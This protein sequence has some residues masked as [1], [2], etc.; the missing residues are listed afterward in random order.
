[1]LERIKILT[2][3]QL[4][5]KTRRHAKKSLRVY[6]D[7]ALKAIFVLILT[8]VIGLLLHVVKNILFIPVNEYFMIFVLLLTQVMSIITA[9][10]GLIVDIYQSKDN[11]IILTLP[12][13]N[14]EIFL[15]KLIVYYIYEFKKNFSFLFPFLVAYGFI[16]KIGFG[17]YASIIPM[18]FILPFISVFFAS[19]I[20][21]IVTIIRNYLNRHTWISFSL[22]IL[23]IIGFFILVFNLVSLI[24][25]NIRIVQL[26]N[27]FIV[28]L[29]KFMQQV[30]SAGSVYTLIGKLMNGTN[31]LI[32]SLIVTIIILVLFAINFLVSRP[33]FFRL[34]SKSNEQARTIKHNPKPVKAKGLFWT[35]LRKEITI[36]K[37]SPNELLDN[38]S[39]LIALPLIIFVLNSIYMNMDRSS[40]GN[41]FILVFNVLITL[42]LITASNTASAAAI[43]TEGYEFVLLKTAP[44]KTK[45][46]AWAK[47]TFN[48]V[49]T[50][51]LLLLSFI[52]FQ[53]ALPVFNRTDIWLL[54][55][56]AF[57]F[58]AS[59][60]LWSFQ[61]D[62]LNPKLSDYAATGSLSNND[63]I[64]KALSNGFA[65]SVVFTMLSILLFVFFKPIAWFVLIAI[66]IV[67]LLFRFWSFRT[68]IDAYFV[69]IEY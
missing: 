26:Y 18:M 6:R 2:K 60:I 25:D 50:S 35:F 62:I 5:N 38:Y 59:Q 53:I 68:C 1:M 20:S 16:T 17:F 63:N 24:P 67:W 56:F 22:I 37:R 55:I 64:A 29:T 28:G 7:F 21:I 47:M 40:L 10:F 36:A 34:T 57:F 30:A 3:L 41:H 33:L 54:F 27:S 43:T 69:D 46:V 44:S 19:I 58:N 61:I 13:K 51:V 11:Q 9:I 8:I 66:A 15:S 31:V 48:F 4:S 65:V 23:F 52:L 42:I 12:A 45:Q 32:N 14:D 49:F 39:V